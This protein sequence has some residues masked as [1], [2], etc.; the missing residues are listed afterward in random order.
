MCNDNHSPALPCALKAR[1]DELLRLG[2]KARCRF[3]EKQ[4]AGAPD[5]RAGDG[6]ALFLATAE[7]NALGPD[8]GCVACF[9]SQ[10]IVLKKR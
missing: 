5:E 6:D 7:G 4:D 1:L 9:H 3:V 8:V 10:G 2:V